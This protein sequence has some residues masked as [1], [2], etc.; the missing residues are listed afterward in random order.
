MRPPVHPNLAPDHQDNQELGIACTI[1][2][3]Q[4]ENLFVG[5]RMTKVTDQWLPRPRR[6]TAKV[7]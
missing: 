2:F 7:R 6:A 3:Q 1:Q 5:P 4:M